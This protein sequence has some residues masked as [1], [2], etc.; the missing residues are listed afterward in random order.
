MPTEKETTI[1]DHE[2]RIQLIEQSC[3]RYDNM[4]EKI[5]ET[6]LCINNGV[7]EIKLNMVKLEARAIFPFAIGGAGGATVF[8]LI[9]LIMFLIGSK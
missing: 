4:I 9:K 1:H 5:E 7:N 6:L 3:E 8:G 2:T